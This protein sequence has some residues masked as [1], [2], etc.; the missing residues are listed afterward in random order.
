MRKGLPT[1]KEVRELAD[2]LWECYETY[3]REVGLTDPTTLQFQ[4]LSNKMHRLA[5]LLEITH[6]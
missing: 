1:A 5:A 6:E 3:K 2:W 4:E